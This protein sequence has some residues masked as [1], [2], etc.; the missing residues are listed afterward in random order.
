MVLSPEYSNMLDKY[1][2]SNLQLKNCYL[3][4]TEHFYL[5][6]DLF[7]FYLQV[8]KILKDNNFVLFCY[9]F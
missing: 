8:L 3:N 6:N 1:Y 4:S 9:T 2:N 7:T 5:E